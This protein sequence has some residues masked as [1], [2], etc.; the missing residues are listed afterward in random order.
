M[1]REFLGR[2]DINFE[3]SIMSSH[4]MLPRVGHMM[5]VIN[6]FRYLK[7]H[8]NARLVFNPTYPNINYDAFPINEWSNYYDAQAEEMPQDMPTPM[9]KKMLIVAYVDAEFAGDRLRRKS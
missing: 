3:T 1:D 8:P 6:I 4:V 7:H 9:G 5:Q 2:I